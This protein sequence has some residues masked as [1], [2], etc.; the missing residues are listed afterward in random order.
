[1]SATSRRTFVQTAAASVGTFAILTG[2]ARGAEFVYKFANNQP[3]SHPMNV[4]AAE[5]LPRILEQSG[6]RLEVQLFPNSQLGADPDMLQQ[7]R[8]GA[9]EI[10]ALSGIN[11]L[12]TLDKRTSLYGV[13]F[14][15]PDYDTMWSAV[16][17]EVGAFIRGV[18]EKLGFYALEKPWDS[19][20]RQITSSTRPIRTPEDLKGFKIRV[21]VSPLFTSTFQALGASPVSVNFAEAYSALQTKIAEGQ[22]NPLT[23]I[24]IAKFFEVQKYC[25][26]TNHMWDGLLSLINGKAWRALP[27]NLQGI[28]ADN[29]NGASLQARADLARLNNTAADDLKRSGLIFNDTDPSAFRGVLSKSG[30]Y[31]QWKETF[32]PETWAVLEKYSGPLV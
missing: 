16:D 1:M 9:L 26:I 7:L 3:V 8:R 2:R 6:G 19:G 13:A 27:S 15:F 18:V 10:F 29:L 24:Y 5:M 22:E 25:A 31:R 12:S 11:V 20:F 4:R 32:G 21:P 30:Y 14:A 28:L 23:Q 17:G